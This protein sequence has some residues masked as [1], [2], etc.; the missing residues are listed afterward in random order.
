MLVDEAESARFRRRASAR[1]PSSVSVPPDCGVMPAIV[2]SRV[3]FPEPAGP[4]TTPY[5]PLG[6]VNVMSVSRK[7]P[8]R[9]ESPRASITRLPAGAGAVEPGTLLITQRAQHRQRNERED[10]E[11]R[12]DGQRLAQS[13]RS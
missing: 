10:G 13:E 6:T 11:D 2:S 8:T 5:A 7:A 4:I 9:A 12:R 3:V 1:R